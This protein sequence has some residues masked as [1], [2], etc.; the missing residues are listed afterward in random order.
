MLLST[1]GNDWEKNVKYGSRQQVKNVARIAGGK[2]MGTSCMDLVVHVWECYK[3]RCAVC[4][5]FSRSLQT[6]M[7]HNINP[8]NHPASSFAYN[9]FLMLEGQYMDGLHAS[10]RMNIENQTFMKLA[11]MGTWLGDFITAW[12]VTD[13]MLQ[14]L[15]VTCKTQY[16]GPQGSRDR[17]E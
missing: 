17:L 14:V 2:W 15:C 13:M 10:S 1:D 8:Y 16:I 6:G 5:L 11:A 12:M 3:T 9:G 4:Y 7:M